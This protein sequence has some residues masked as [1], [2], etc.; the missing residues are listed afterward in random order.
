MRSPIGARGCCVSGRDG[1]RFR[2]MEWGRKNREAGR[3]F[4]EHQIE[5]VNFQVAL[6]QA[7]AQRR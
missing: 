6:Q 1:M 2:N 3:P 7:A 4:I 5:I